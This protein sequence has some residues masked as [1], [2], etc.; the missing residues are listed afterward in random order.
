[1]LTQFIDTYMRY[2]GRWVNCIHNKFNAVKRSIGCIRIHCWS[3]AAFYSRI[4][5]EHAVFYPIEIV[6]FIDWNDSYWIRQ[7]TAYMIVTIDS[8]LYNVIHSGMSIIDE[9][10]SVQYT[11]YLYWFL[12]IYC[13]CPLT[14]SCAFEMQITPT[15][16]AFRGVWWNVMKAYLP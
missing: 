3:G 12:V 16:R 1:M 7:I 8:L 4:Y 6:Q 15:I 11:G 2:Q 14:A 5:D 13:Q 9:L 10:A